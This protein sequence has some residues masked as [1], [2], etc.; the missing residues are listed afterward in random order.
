MFKSIILIAAIVAASSANAGDCYSEGT[1]VGDLQK[2]SQKGLINKSWEGELVMEG[3]KIKS[4]ANGVSGGNVWRFSVL[5]PSVAKVID[6]AM[7]TGNKVALRYCQTL[8]PMLQSDTGY[9]ITQ[10]VERK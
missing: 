7:M 2:F 1:R 9:R 3:T 5:D 4:S 6:N 8:L 10:A